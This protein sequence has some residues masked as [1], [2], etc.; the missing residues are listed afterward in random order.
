[1]NGI[2]S[3]IVNLAND[4][5]LDKRNDSNGRVEPVDVSLVEERSNVFV[6][7][8]TAIVIGVGLIGFVGWTVEMVSPTQ[9]EQRRT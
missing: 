9:V 2:S 8:L 6:S 7:I 1:M 5:S 3:A 4:T